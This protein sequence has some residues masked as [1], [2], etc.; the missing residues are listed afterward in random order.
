VSTAR[1]RSPGLTA[2]DR[3]CA[4]LNLR[5]AQAQRHQQSAD[6][7]KDEQDAEYTKPEFLA[8]DTAIGVSQHIDDIAYMDLS[9]TSAKISTNYRSEEC[10]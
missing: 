9:I 3:H 7:K 8:A 4:G 2:I 1:Q 5:T 10:L 6:S